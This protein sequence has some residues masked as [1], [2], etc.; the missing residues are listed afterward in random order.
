MPSSRYKTES[1]HALRT[2]RHRNQ[3]QLA[4]DASKN[5]YRNRVPS[6]LK[7]PLPIAMPK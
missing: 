7:H 4:I 3:D 5:S 2:A 6:A 1:V